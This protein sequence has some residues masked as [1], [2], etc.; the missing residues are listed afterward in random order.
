MARD[1][2]SA[3]EGSALDFSGHTY[4]EL[5]TAILAVDEEAIRVGANEWA[6]LRRRL[7][8]RI[9]TLRVMIHKLAPDWDSP[10]GRTALGALRGHLDRMQNLAKAARWN[11]DRF[12]AL[13]ETYHKTMKEFR[14][15]DAS[16]GGQAE[17]VRNPGDNEALPPNLADRRQ[18]RAAQLAHDI[19]SQIALT[20]A[21]LTVPEPPSD[22]EG[23]GDGTA[24]EGSGSPGY[25]SGAGPRS[26]STPP[27]SSTGWG[28]PGVIAPPPS[29]AGSPDSLSRAPSGAT[30]PSGRVTV[31]GQ[32]PATGSAPSS[33]TRGG[34]GVTPGT[35]PDMG[36]P[37]RG[38]SGSG[39]TSAG[40]GVIGAPGGGTGISGN[41]PPGGGN[42]PKVIGGG[43]RP[44]VGS[45]AEPP[46]GASQ[47]GTPGAMPPGAHGGA[48]RPGRGSPGRRTNYEQGEPDTF[49]DTR[50]RTKP[51]L[52]QPS[53]PAKP[54]ATDPGVIGQQKQKPAETGQRGQWQQPQPA[55]SPEGF[56]DTLEDGTFTRRDGAKFT[57]RRRGSGA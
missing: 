11:E 39:G 19:Y 28:A 1:D 54:V 7:N 17:V 6:D 31:P 24:G 4:E 32:T 56:P 45:P 13:H 52:G 41:P 37:G 35:R 55:P 38:S 30:R 29:K 8:D 22:I 44:T 36:A 34:F 48:G 43:P 46:P 27:G 5:R 33:D 49:R 47:P 2:G 16:P 14:E 25:G 53:N 23:L 50:H 10:A 51:V 12:D 26:G 18:P 15:L 9:S 42:G 57:V 20:S 40:R 21:T 3:G